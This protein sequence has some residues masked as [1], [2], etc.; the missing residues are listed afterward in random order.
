MRTKTRLYMNACQV[1]LKFNVSCVVHFAASVSPTHDNIVVPSP[2]NKSFVVTWRDVMFGNY[3]AKPLNTKVPL[4]SNDHTV[5]MPGGASRKQC[6]DGSSNINLSRRSKPD[7]G[8]FNNVSWLARLPC[9]AI[10]IKPRRPF[11]R[12]G[13]GMLPSMPQRNGDNIGGKKPQRL[14]FKHM[15]EDGLVG[16]VPH[17]GVSS[18]RLRFRFNHE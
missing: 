4:S 8:T 13:A 3:G 7:F 15:C 1:R 2:F 14:R 11:N 18:A 12:F 6:T 9:H 10:A 16:G 17:P 5:D